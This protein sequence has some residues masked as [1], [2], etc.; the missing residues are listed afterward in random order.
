MHFRAA[1]EEL[2]DLEADPAEQSPLSEGVE[3]PVRRRLLEAAREHVRR[4][5]EQRNDK[6]RVGSLLRE[7]RLEWPIF[8]ERVPVP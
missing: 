1:A 3:R 8:S 6:L 5:A 2:Y 4:S 7:H